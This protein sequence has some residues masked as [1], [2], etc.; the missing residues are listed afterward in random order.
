MAGTSLAG[1]ILGGALASRIPARVLRWV[2]ITF[3]VVVGVAYLVR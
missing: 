3:S 1:G 2:V